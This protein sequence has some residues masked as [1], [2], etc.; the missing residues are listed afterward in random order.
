VAVSSGAMTADID[1][2]LQA[3]FTAYI[4]KPVDI[5]H[6]LALVERVR[7]APEALSA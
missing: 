7:A 3:G 4:T 6:L 5:G 2:A 1:L